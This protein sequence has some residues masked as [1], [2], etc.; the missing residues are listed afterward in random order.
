VPYP[1]R[2]CLLAGRTV[3]RQPQHL[4]KYRLAHR[5]VRSMISGGMPERDR[6]PIQ[7]AHFDVQP[8]TPLRSKLV[9]TRGEASDLVAGK[10]DEIRRRPDARNDRV[11]LCERPRMES[12]RNA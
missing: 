3:Q 7:P 6:L 5:V 1:V 11:D 4:A 8:V 10:D 12:V 9:G 2:Q